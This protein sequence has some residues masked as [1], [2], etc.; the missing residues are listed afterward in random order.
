M[1][2]FLS[3]NWYKLMIGLSALMLSFGIMV[4][5][6]NTATAKNLNKTGYL[7]SNE[8]SEGNYVFFISNGYMYRIQK[9]K[10][11]DAFTDPLAWDDKA[12]I[13]IGGLR[14]EDQYYYR[15]RKIH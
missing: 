10:F 8:Y 9:G 7:Q 4:Y 6:I 13:S 11:N 15:Y 12:Q 1:Q 5:S 3:K 14:T 2:S